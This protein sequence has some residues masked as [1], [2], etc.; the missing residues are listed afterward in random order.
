MLLE[1]L[2]AITALGA[3]VKADRP[4]NVTICDYYTPLLLGEP[5]SAAS[6]QK[7]MQR[8]THTFILGNYTT[9][10]VGIK[11]AGIAAPANFSG[12]EVNLLNYFTG[13]YYSTN[14]YNNASTGVAKNF[15]DDGGATAL[16]ADK[17]AD[18]PA[19]TNSSNQ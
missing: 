10:N 1:T 19:D 5:N 16:L 7:L 12:H 17:P 3:V 11:V 2:I 14:G 15:L 18:K 6:Q 9:P 4:A 8:L 13:A